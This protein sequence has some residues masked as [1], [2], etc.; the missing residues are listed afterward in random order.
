M[1]SSLYCILLMSILV[2]TTTRRFHKNKANIGTDYEYI[3]EK[4][5]HSGTNSDDTKHGG[6]ANVRRRI[7]RR[8]K[9]VT[10]RTSVQSPEGSKRTLAWPQKC[11][12]GPAR[13]RCQVILFNGNPIRICMYYREEECSSLD[14]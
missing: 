8:M 5:Y 10:R 2:K 14:K 3:D 1:Y 12:L 6:R 4:E 9:H 11:V 13:V 7:H